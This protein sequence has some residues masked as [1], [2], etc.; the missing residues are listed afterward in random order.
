MLIIRERLY[1]HPVY[2]NLHDTMTV[3]NWISISTLC[4]SQMS[5][6]VDATQLISHWLYLFAEPPWHSYGCFR[7][8]TRLALYRLQRIYNRWS[9]AAMLFHVSC[10]MLEVLINT[11]VCVCGVYFRY[12]AFWPDH[13]YILSNLLRIAY[14]IICEFIQEVWTVRGSNLCGDDIFQTRGA[15]PVYY[16][17]NTRSFPRVK[18]QRPGVYHSPHLAPRLKKE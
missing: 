3:H 6:T 7:Y 14:W 2:Y 18:R 15:Q 10:G 17:M 4:E 8:R 11:F 13:T 5:H 16:I 12:S 1:A 9:S